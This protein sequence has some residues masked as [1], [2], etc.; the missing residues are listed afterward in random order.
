MW[1][2]QIWICFYC[3]VGLFFCFVFSLL[4][5]YWILILALSPG[6]SDVLVLNWF[7]SIRTRL[8]RVSEALC[9][10]RED[11]VF[12]WQWADVRER[13]LN[14]VSFSNDSRW[15]SVLV[16]DALNGILWPFQGSLFILSA[17]NLGFIRAPTPCFSLLQFLSSQHYETIR[18]SA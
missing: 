3:G 5:L 15:G 4:C 7:L 16:K 18:S 17:E 1:K 11:L 14:P 6:L 13:C 9:L 8:F 12:S 10:S 2:L